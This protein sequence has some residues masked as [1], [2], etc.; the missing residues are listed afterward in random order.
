MVRFLFLI[1]IILCAL[2]MLYLHMSGKTLRQ[3][4]KGFINIAVF[5]AVVAAFYTVL[6][7]LTD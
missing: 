1:P 5:S 6:L 2:W 7:W 3:G 4:F